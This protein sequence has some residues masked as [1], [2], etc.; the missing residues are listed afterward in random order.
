MAEMFGVN[1][2]G[3]GNDDCLENRDAKRKI[4]VVIEKKAALRQ[5][6]KDLLI[7]EAM[8][9]KSEEKRVH[10][11]VKEAVMAGHSMESLHAA[12]CSA[13][14]GDVSQVLFPKTAQLLRRQMILSDGDIEK[15]AFPAPEELIDRN[16]PMTI[17]N[18]RQALLSSIDALKKHTKNMKLYRGALVHIDDDLGLL[19]QKLKEI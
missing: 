5:R 4:L 12:S 10:Y 15:L 11:L 14:T 16:V 6:V 8:M 7:K 1:E 9:F 17:V 13:G 19:R 2:N 18:G 3:N